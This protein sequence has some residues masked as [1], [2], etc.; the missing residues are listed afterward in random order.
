M[1]LSL[2]QKGVIVIAI[3]LI[4]ILAL[5]ISVGQVHKKVAAAEIWAQH[6][7]QVIV[8][9]QS[10]SQ[11]LLQ[12]ESAIR[13]YEITGDAR[14]L[15]PYDHARVALPSISKNLEDFVRD[16][17]SQERYAHRL[18][19]LVAS[20]MKRL[21]LARGLIETH[22]APERYTNTIRLGNASMVEFANAMSAFIVE[23]LR[24]NKERQVELEH[25]WQKLNVVLVL[26]AIAAC[27]ITLVI[28]LLYNRGMVRR[29]SKLRTK[30]MQFAAS[31]EIGELATE[32]DEIGEL[33]NTW[34]IM[35]QIVTD[36][37][38]VLLR[39]QLLARYAHDIILFLR[40]SDGFILEANAGA[41]EKY[42]YEH[43]EL[44]TMNS[45][46]LRAPV[47]HSE[48]N[49]L[50]VAVQSKASSYETVHQRK[51]GTMFPVE[52]TSQIGNLGSDQILVA[53]V[54]DITERRR[55]ERDRD[56][57]F[58]LSLD[59]ICVC[60]FEGRFVRLN[61]AWEVTTGFTTQELCSAPFM[62]FVHPEDREATG[63]VMAAL[64]S[65]QEIL[66]H[67]NR[68]RCKDGSYKWL[69]WNATPSVEEGLI[70][71]TA[72]DVTQ[73]KDIEN[74][75]ARARDQAT[76]ASRLKSQ[77]LA[78]M[79]H[80]IRTPM[81][82]VIG[83]T[84]LL[85]TTQLTG[86]QREFTTTVRESALALLT[87]IN[88]ILDFSKL[89]A[90]KMELE[91]IDFSPCLVTESV[92]DLLAT[93]A[94]AKGLELQAFV[95]K[96]VPTTL[97]GDAGRL[98]Q[99]LLNLA[100]NAI[101]FTSNGRV[102][103]RVSTES[104]NPETTVLKFNVE[105][106]GLGISEQA[107]GR[108]FQPFTQADGATTRR[109]GGT[110]L[111]LSIS[112]RIIELMGGEVGVSSTENLGSNFWFVVPLESVATS[113]VDLAPSPLMGRRA[114]VVD[115]DANT[116]D[117]LHHY[118][119]SWNLRN[120]RAMNGSEALKI[121]RA[122]ALAGDPYDVAIVDFAMPGMDGFELIQAVRSDPMLSNL[123]LI[124]VTAFDKKDRGKEAL[125]LGFSSYLT[126]PVKQSQLFDS[127][128]HAV[129]GERAA[130][131]NVVIPIQSHA[132]KI[133]GA[134]GAQTCQVLLAEDNAINQQVAVAQLGRLG[135]SPQIAHNGRE[136]FEAFQTG[137]YALIFM[138]CQMPEVDG[139]EA[140]KLIR[141]AERL[142]G[143]HVPI[144]AMTAN[145]VEGDRDLCIAAG[146]D[147]YLSKPVD[148]TKLRQMVDRWLPV[149]NKT[150][151]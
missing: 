56:R 115:D 113:D 60:T 27:L 76:E 46:L 36:K 147:D 87:I 20:R 103:L 134:A 97:R 31:G 106:T 3:P 126:K 121:L 95:M 59:L 112:K 120:G 38:Q 129:L 53:I 24:L 35:A 139:F 2:G 78:N 72:R 107:L 77:F 108:L 37:Q 28:M 63:S 40:A 62:D 33:D 12:A 13:A 123:K 34:R 127:L 17:P 70:Y 4:F 79:S 45:N 80:E 104:S 124:L 51:D 91:P 119:T 42:G 141:K 132:A 150:I 90:G 105:D 118:V 137:E 81:N 73:R 131:S 101:K 55:S 130:I 44:L 22:H 8:L 66:G 25:A 100:G 21:E 48:F 117:I 23:E 142:T 15:G 138:D 67:E 32:R 83:M 128:A 71:A 68:Y 109:F 6:A 29:L 140:T 49:D 39:Y 7:E 96:D 144:V 86:E 43:D 125:R 94:R 110:G 11:N 151:A 19:T 111:G 102:T 122:E 136:A 30:A 135:I 114:L 57:F 52:V 116:C 146:M 93:Q 58:D 85:L 89:E 145:A 14:L 148:M 5:I 9:A 54:R 16:N 149:E 99:V 50:L 18:Q 47:A 82:G 26:G 133:D 143:G 10:L 65:G 84:E 74:T 61:P 92:A 64:T 69:L 75:L 1:R 41:V 98:R 88:E